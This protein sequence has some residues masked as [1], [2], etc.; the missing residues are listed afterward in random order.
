MW[1]VIRSDAENT[2][3]DGKELPLPLTTP[4]AATKSDNDTFMDSYKYTSV[5][6]ILISEA[7]VFAYGPLPSVGDE[8]VLRVLQNTSDVIGSMD[9]ISEEQQRCGYLKG[10][11][12]EMRREGYTSLI[13]DNLSKCM[14]MYCTAH[15]LPEVYFNAN[16][17]H[18]AVLK[19]RLPATSNDD[20]SQVSALT[21]DGEESGLVDLPVDIGM[22]QRFSNGEG[23]L[24]TSITSKCLYP[25][26]FIQFMANHDKYSATLQAKVLANHM[27]RLT[28]LNGE[29]GLGSR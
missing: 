16:M 17:L 29:D 28:D 3:H 2:T 8:A 10:D 6:N 11:Q 4:S 23:N 7:F 20:D 24:A 14:L 15:N 26:G 5:S 21:G 22:F 19:A 25:V 9:Y 18:Q 1:R 13:H 27:F 12:S